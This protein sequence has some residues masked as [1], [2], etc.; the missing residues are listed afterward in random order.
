M[1]STALQYGATW[2]LAGINSSLRVVDGL[3]IVFEVHCLA[4]ATLKSGSSFC[5]G[6]TAEPLWK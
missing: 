6:R 1:T 4:S 2:G 3:A 5:G